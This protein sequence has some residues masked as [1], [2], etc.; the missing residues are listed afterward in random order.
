MG[1]AILKPMMEELGFLELIKMI[2][3]PLNHYMNIKEDLFKE[4]QMVLEF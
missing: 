2:H 3:L 4:S 1:G